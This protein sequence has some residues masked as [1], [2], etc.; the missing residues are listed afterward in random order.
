M[1]ACFDCCDLGDEKIVGVCNAC[2]LHFRAVSVLVKQKT[3]LDGVLWKMM[4]IE[5]L[6]E[7]PAKEIP[8]LLTYL[9]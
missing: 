9:S 3:Q 6:G 5:H 8:G 4:N 7:D 1:T 2:L